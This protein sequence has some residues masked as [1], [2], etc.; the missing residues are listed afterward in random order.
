MNQIPRWGSANVK[1][2]GT[3]FSRPGDL[4]YLEFVY[5]CSVFLF[6]YAVSESTEQVSTEYGDEEMYMKLFRASLILVPM[7]AV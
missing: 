6:K 5:P 1:Q 7:A 4:F 2:H 3:K